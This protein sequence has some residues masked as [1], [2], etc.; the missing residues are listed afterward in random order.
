VAEEASEAVVASA[1]ESGDVDATVAAA[2]RGGEI[3]VGE[4]GAEGSGRDMAM[5]TTSRRAKLQQQHIDINTPL[6]REG[7]KEGACGRK[8]WIVLKKK[9]VR[10]GFENASIYVVTPRCVP[11]AQ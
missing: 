5:W 8:K 11:D 9:D 4:A 3:G 10:L 1:T 7:R 2:E 6:G